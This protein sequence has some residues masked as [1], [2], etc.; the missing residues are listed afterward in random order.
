MHAKAVSK[1][2]PADASSMA[3]RAEMERKEALQ[4]GPDDLLH[5][6]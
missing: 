5:E 1:V 6:T 2:T 4:Y 3:A